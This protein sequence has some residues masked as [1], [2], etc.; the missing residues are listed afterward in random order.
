VFTPCPTATRCASSSSSC[1]RER[2]L[3]ALSFLRD[4]FP[5]SPSSALRSCFHYSHPQN[6][7][8]RIDPLMTPFCATSPFPVDFTATLSSSPPRSNTA[9]ASTSGTSRGCLK[10]AELGPR[11]GKVKHSPTTSHRRVFSPL[12]SNLFFFFPAGQQGRIGPTEENSIWW[13]TSRTSS[14]ASHHL[15]ANFS[16][17]LFPPFR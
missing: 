2:V 10:C 15:P 11:F 8:Y 13:N 5:M 12:P 9:K 7:Q 6:A 17:F 14:S 16:P 1:R 3:T 4:H